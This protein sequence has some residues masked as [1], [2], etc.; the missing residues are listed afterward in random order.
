[1]PASLVADP[2]PS[3]SAAYSRVVTECGVTGLSPKPRVRHE[4]AEAVAKGGKLQLPRD[5]IEE[6][7]VDQPNAVAV[8][9]IVV[10]ESHP[11]SAQPRISAGV[12]FGR[13]SDCRFP[14]NQHGP[15]GHEQDQGGSEV[16]VL[17]AE[18]RA[19]RADEV[20][21][22]PSCCGHADRPPERPATT[23]AAPAISAAASSQSLS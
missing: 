2:G 7:A 4:D 6:V 13:E 5:A 17:D 12:S 9:S 15:G 22:H 20:K 23:P 11:G 1:M 3:T 16:P 8:A 18:M 14:Q 19:D 21:D 10:G